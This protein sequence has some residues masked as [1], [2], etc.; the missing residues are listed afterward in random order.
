[1]RVHL[2]QAKGSIGKAIIALD[3]TLLPKPSAKI[4]YV[5]LED[6]I[7]NEGSPA[8]QSLPTITMLYLP[9]R[10]R[11]KGLAIQ[12]LDQA[13]AYMAKHKIPYAA[14]DNFADDFWKSALRQR[15]NNVV[16]SKPYRGTSRFGFVR[17][18]KSIKVDHIL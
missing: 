8:E 10:M 18:R 12:L 7:W 11:G 16:L 6:F 13:I 4:P 1:M 2:L 15:P 9:T 17:L 3:G 5:I 14:F